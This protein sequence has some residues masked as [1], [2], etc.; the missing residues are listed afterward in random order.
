MRCIGKVFIQIEVVIRQGF[1]DLEFQFKETGGRLI[2][3]L[4]AKVAVV[5]LNADPQYSYVIDSE[6]R[7]SPSVPK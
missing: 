5:Y 3:G 4:R 1:W 6:Q 7:P 2:D